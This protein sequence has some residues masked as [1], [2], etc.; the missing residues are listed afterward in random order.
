MQLLLFNIG[1]T[2]FDI[3]IALVLFFYFFGWPLAGVILAVMVAY[4]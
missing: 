1:P 2:F 3:V 4:G